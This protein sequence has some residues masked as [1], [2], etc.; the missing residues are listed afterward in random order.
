M[1]EEPVYED[2][3][4]KKTKA[5]VVSEYERK[6]ADLK[7]NYDKQ[8]KKASNRDVIVVIRGAQALCLGIFTIGVSMGAGDVGAAYGLPVSSL[9]IT[10]TLFGGFG[11]IICEIFARLAEKW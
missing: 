11:S 3:I 8:I 5:E 9:S 7:E 10:T 2:E 4:K 1:S 6:I